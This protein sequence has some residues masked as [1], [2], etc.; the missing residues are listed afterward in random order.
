MPVPPSSA[1]RQ[2][3]KSHRAGS[4]ASKKK[5]WAVR[6]PWLLIRQEEGLWEASGEKIEIIEMKHHS[7]DPTH[8]NTYLKTYYNKIKQKDFF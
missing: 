3:E 4:V 2:N 6:R 8:V 7:N 1:Y 5:P